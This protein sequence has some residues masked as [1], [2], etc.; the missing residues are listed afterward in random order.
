MMEPATMDFG[1]GSAGLPPVRSR[2]KT[3]KGEPK[4]PQVADDTDSK[5]WGT[6]LVDPVTSGA[7]V[8]D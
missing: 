2:V 7:V 8:L 5:V 1:R 3:G 6:F 4:N